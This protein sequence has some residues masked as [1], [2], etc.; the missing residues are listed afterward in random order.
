MRIRTTLL[1]ASIAALPALALAQTQPSAPASPGPPP[2]AT[3]P[4]A[5]PAH[6]DRA[7]WQQRRAE[8]RQKYEQLSADDKAKVD[9]INKQIRALWQEKMQI[10]GMDKS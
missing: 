2:A 10:L 7:Y 8:A 3:S 1:A 6:H 5:A 4:S 9:A